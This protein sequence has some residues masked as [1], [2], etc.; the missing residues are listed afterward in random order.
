MGLRRFAIL[1]L[2]VAAFSTLSQAQK[3]DVSFVAGGAFVSEDH[4]APGVT[5]T[6]PCPLAFNF[7]TD[8]HVFYEGTGAIRLANFKLASLH[9]EVPVAGIPSAQVVFSGTPSSNA[10]KLSSV[11][12]TP[13]LRVK[14]APG[15]PVSPFASIGGGWAHYN[16]AG[17]SM[18]KGALQFG[19]GVDIKTRIPLLG[20]RAEVR[21]FF[22][23]QP[24]FGIVSIQTLGSSSLGRRQ[25]V[26]AGGGIVLRF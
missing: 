21:D 23:G 25:N 12:V 11:F 13:S 22:T 6:I 14:F 24:D 18:N 3:A 2:V 9:L 16:L 1:L 26:L 7:R 4:V 19:G 17:T 20:F 15:F 10:L 8:T 5:C